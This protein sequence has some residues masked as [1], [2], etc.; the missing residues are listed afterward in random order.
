MEDGHIL[1]QT[2]NRAHGLRGEPAAAGQEIEDVL[3][4]RPHDPSA[5]ANSSVDVPVDRQPKGFRVQAPFVGLAGAGALEGAAVDNGL[6]GG[7]RGSATAVHSRSSSHAM[8][9]DS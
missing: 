5:G 1:L 3:T 8:I 7:R 2:P 6:W 9:W 4:V